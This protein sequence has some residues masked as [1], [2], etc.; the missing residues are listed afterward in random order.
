MVKREKV[1]INFKK[2]IRQW[3]L[4]FMRFFVQGEGYNITE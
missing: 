1:Y 3:K 4:C 2:R